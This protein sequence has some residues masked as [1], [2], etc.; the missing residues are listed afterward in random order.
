MAGLTGG[1][2]NPKP[3]EVSLAHNGVLFLDELPEFSRSAMEALRQP[4]E[5]GLVTISRAS[6]R[7]TFPA[8]FM[9]VA[10]MNPCPCGF[11]GHPTKPCNC[12][13]SM[14]THYLGRV[15]GPLLDRVDLHVEV[16]AV[17][18]RSL[19]ARVPGESSAVVRERVMRAREIQRARFG[20][21]GVYCNAQIPR[22]L[23]EKFCPLTPAAERLLAIAFDKLRL[24]ARGYDR[25][26]KVARTIAD[27]DGSGSIDTAHI[28]EA[29]QYRTLDRKYWTR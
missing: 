14:I 13:S 19:A 10:A 15:S 8:N 12:S 25:V 5:D 3:G 11:Y 9:F 20:N 21:T 17:D 7:V 1:G 2:S 4:V 24:S 16:L 29:V 6:T 28:S 22:S 18:Y 27:L 23:L 26:L